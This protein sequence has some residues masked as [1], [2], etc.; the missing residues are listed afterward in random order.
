VILL[1]LMMPRVDGAGVMKFLAEYHP[2]QLSN[3]IVMTAFGARAGERLDSPPA[4]FL[5]KPFDIHALV[6]EIGKCV[7]GAACSDEPAS[8][9][10]RVDPDA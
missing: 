6:A 1:D 10:T 8:R 4:H 5:E 7:E 9:D 2:D 3:V